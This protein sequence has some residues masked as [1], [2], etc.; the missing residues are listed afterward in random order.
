MTAPEEE[1]TA[2][3]PQPVR[4]RVVGWAAAALGAMPADDVPSTLKAVA[5]FAPTKRAG[6]ID[7]C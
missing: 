2:P 1:L 7:A 6:G 4:Q 3:L 5:R